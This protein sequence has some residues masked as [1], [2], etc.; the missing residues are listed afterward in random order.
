MSSRVIQ[1]KKW[2]KVKEIVGIN[3]F[4]PTYNKIIAGDINPKEG[5]IVKI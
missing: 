4:L 1:S 2:M 5:I 3:L